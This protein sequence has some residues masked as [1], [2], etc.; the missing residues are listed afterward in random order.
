MYHNL[1]PAENS[2]FRN[3][4]AD[5]FKHI[6]DF[7]IDK[8]IVAYVFNDKPTL[9]KLIFENFIRYPYFYNYILRDKF[10]ELFPNVP[11]ILRRS[12]TEIFTFTLDDFTYNT[13]Y[14]E[15]VF[16]NAISFEILKNISILDFY[17]IDKSQLNSILFNKIMQV[18]SY[19]YLVQTIDGRELIRNNI[20]REIVFLE[21]IV[22]TNANWFSVVTTKMILTFLEDLLLKSNHN[23]QAVVSPDFTVMLDFFKRYFIDGRFASHY[24]FD[25]NYEMFINLL[26]EQVGSSDLALLIYSYEKNEKTVIDELSS[27]I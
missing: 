18:A 20:L 19:Y 21:D 10:C 22:L 14:L 25:N 4:I 27:T 7:I 26:A 15:E 9:K 6:P 23:A 11:D 24:L 12:T 3:I 1:S 5:R 16:G 2:I 13:V 17:D 8:Y